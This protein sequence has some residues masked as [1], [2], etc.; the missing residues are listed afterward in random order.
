MPACRVV[1]AVVSRK[2][3]HQ[4]PN[5]LEAIY[6]YWLLDISKFS[7]HSES[8][9][10]AWQRKLFLY[11]KGYIC[12]RVL[13]RSPDHCWQYAHTGTIDWA[14]ATQARNLLIIAETAENLRKIC[15]GILLTLLTDKKVIQ[16]YRI[17]DSADLSLWRLGLD[18]LLAFWHVR[19]R[20]LCT[21]LPW[22]DVQV[23]LS[24]KR[25]VL[26]TTAYCKTHT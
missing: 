6:W 5:S 17:Q 15:E 12:N 3:G 9:K 18:S 8:W 24:T 10:T 25:Q 22:Q 20:S 16:R 4:S 11:G 13:T 26:E 14:L 7:G 1:E 19:S 21:I 23:P 2:T